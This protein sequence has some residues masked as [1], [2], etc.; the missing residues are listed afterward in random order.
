MVQFA[1]QFTVHLHFNQV[2][3]SIYK[4]TC[5]SYE[6]LTT[7]LINLT[8]E[9]TLS[10]INNQFC[11]QVNK[12]VLG[13]VHQYHRDKATAVRKTTSCLDRQSCVHEI[14]IIRDKTAWQRT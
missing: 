8:M 14:E 7:L 10:E 1:V 6:F 3:L 2:L 12:E 9:G 4:N 5:P 11:R 13:I